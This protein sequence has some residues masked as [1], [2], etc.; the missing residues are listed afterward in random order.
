MLV[1]KG[2]RMIGFL[3]L[4]REVEEKS[5]SVYKVLNV[6]ISYRFFISV[7]PVMLTL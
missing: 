5:A 4:L 6:F 2:L 7:L 1:C 3:F